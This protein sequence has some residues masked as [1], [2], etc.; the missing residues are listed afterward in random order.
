MAILKENGWIISK[1]TIDNR[2]AVA[3]LAAAMMWVRKA[4]G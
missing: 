4:R 2:A 1:P 3:R